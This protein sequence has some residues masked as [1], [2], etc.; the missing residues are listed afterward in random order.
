MKKLILG[1]AAVVLSASAGAVDFSGSVGYA[2]DYIWRGITKSNGDPIFM[3]S[4]RLAHDS[5]VYGSVNFY[6]G[7]DFPADTDESQELDYTVGFAKDIGDGLF[8]LDVGYTRHTY[9]GDDSDALQELHGTVSKGPAR[10]TMFQVIGLDDNEFAPYVVGSVDVFDL[11]ENKLPVSVSAFYG[12]QLT[13]EDED[14]RVS[15][16]GV[17]TSLAIKERGSLNYK[18]SKFSEDDEVTH[19]FGLTVTF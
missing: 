10:V 16:F 17:V 3:G 11:F 7:V 15:D 19:T 14:T 5:G 2:S 4:G 12:T 1:I 18:V 9:V 13:T 8:G 6:T